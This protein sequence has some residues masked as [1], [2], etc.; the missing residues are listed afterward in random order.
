VEKQESFT[1]LVFGGSAGAHRINLYMIEA[2]ERLKD[3]GSRL[4]VIHQT[5]EA[6]FSSIKAA[7]SSLP[8]K[9]EILPFIQRMDHAYAEA[10]LV[11][12]RAGATTIAELTALGKP[13]ILVPYPYAAYDHQ[14]WNAQALKEWGA[15]EM[16]LDRELSGEK[17][18]AEIRALH[19]D[20]ERLKKMAE[21]ARKLGQPE[22]AE[23][24][25]DECH[26]LVEK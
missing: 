14:R 13:A 24:I 15:A 7:Y 19:S 22:A 10:D 6:D 26:V 4:R 16:I 23:R 12:C 5:G 3:L 18:A 25:V 1:L 9:A 2:L 21:A 8:F 11:V 20:R 17:L